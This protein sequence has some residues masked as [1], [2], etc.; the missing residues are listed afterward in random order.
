MVLVLGMGLL[1]HG[2]GRAGGAEWPA[3]YEVAFYVT[4]NARI[5]GLR[6]GVFGDG[7]QI[8][9]SVPVAFKTSGRSALYT[10]EG[11]SPLVFFREE[12]V[13]G[14]N[15]G[16][17]I[18][19]RPMARVNLQ[20]QVDEMVLI[21]FKNPG[22]GDPYIARPVDIRPDTI[23]EGHIVLF[24]ATRQV[25]LGAIGE[26]VKPENTGVRA[27]HPGVNPAV[28]IAPR[29][30]VRLAFEFQDLGWHRVFNREYDCNPD[31]RLLL[32][33]YPP[34]FPGSIDLGGRLIRFAGP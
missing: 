3:A 2:L 6:Y 1:G 24:N 20:P 29:G 27:I 10:Y 28:R 21:F 7:G 33:I 5:K 11:P 30:R 19:R 18:E 15:G 17:A 25:L 8:E 9:A 31:E 13:R 12:T 34:R 16:L 22:E 14:L 32:V 4:A 23:P 26:D